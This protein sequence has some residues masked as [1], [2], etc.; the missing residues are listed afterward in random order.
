[1]KK[2]IFFIMF[3]L[4]TSLVNA[5]KDFDKDGMP[6][7]WEK[8]YNLRYDVNDANLDPDNDGLTNLQEYEQGTDP[9]VYDKK[10][11]FFATIFSFFGENILKIFLGIAAIVI[12]YFFFKIVVE[13]SKIKRKKKKKEK[14]KPVAI[15]KYIPLQQRKIFTEKKIKQ[16]F[17]KKRLKKFKKKHKRISHLTYHFEEKPGI[18]LDLQPLPYSSSK[19]VREIKKKI[20]PE[21]KT[22]EKGSIFDRLPKRE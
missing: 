17:D 13:F 19:K 11:T 20:T 6:D 18:D 3:I 5:L 4:L 9:L 15:E 16:T 10:N 7:S 1:M 14:V 12:I 22:E 2:I 21:K 8:K